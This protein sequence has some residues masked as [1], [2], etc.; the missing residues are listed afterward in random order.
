MKNVFKV[1]TPAMSATA[2]YIRVRF[3]WK[4]DGDL[5]LDMTRNG[6]TWHDEI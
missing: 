2:P 5:L 1:P 3:F 6:R 4:M